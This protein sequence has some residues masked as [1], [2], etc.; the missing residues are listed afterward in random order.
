MATER[1]L[2]QLKKAR[3]SRWRQAPTVDERFWRTV[4]KSDPS[5][6]WLWTGY[7]EPGG[8]GIFWNKRHMKAHRYAWESMNGPVPGK[9]CLDHLCRN[10]RCVNLAHLEVVTNRVNIL[11]GVSVVAQTARAAACMRG[12][13]LTPDNCRITARGHR[14]CRQCE[15]DTRRRYYEKHPEM[16]LKLDQW[17]KN[18]KR[19]KVT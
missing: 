4:D 7:V 9:L 11:R 14:R 18:Y 6:C 13:Q 3:E 19:K 1:H 8:Y 16:K 10:R 12:H 17:R 15:R 2:E 5:G